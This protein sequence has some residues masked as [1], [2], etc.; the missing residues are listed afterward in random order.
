MILRADK[1]L[2]P[3]A[4]FLGVIVFVL[5]SDDFSCAAEG[6]LLLAFVTLFC[7]GVITCVVIVE[8]DNECFIVLGVFLLVFV[9]LLCWG[10]IAWVVICVDVKVVLVL[11]DENPLPKEGRDRLDRI[12]WSPQYP[13]SGLAEAKRATMFDDGALFRLLSDTGVEGLLRVAAVTGDRC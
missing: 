1:L 2:L 3:F 9:A 4:R 5:R 10:V 11:G 8:A 7:W 13:P 6:V 12:F